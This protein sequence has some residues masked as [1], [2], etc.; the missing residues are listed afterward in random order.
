MDRDELFEVPCDVLIPAA[1]GNVIT[2]KNVRKI[3][4]RLII[5]GAN[6]PINPEADRILNEAGIPIVPDI[7]A[8]S[9]GVTGSY[10]EW[11][12]NLTQFYWEEPEVYQKLENVL[13]KAYQE[14]HDLHK[15]ESVSL[16]T[17]AFM[18]GIKRVY[19]AMLLRGV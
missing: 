12:Q 4:T 7:L 1:L 3:K 13:L 6:N 17:A 14:V 18:V 8:N 19:E 9:G 15:R 2:E 16:R 10:F 11:T 5:E